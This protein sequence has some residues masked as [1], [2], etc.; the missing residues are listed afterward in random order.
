MSRRPEL[1]SCVTATVVI[2]RI[3]VSLGLP[4]CLTLTLDD[5]RTHEPPA[6]VEPLRPNPV[7][8]DTW[9]VCRLLG[10]ATADEGIYGTDLGYTAPLPGTDRLAV[11]FG[12]TW[13]EVGDACQYPVE[14][15]DDLQATLPAQRP[16]ELGA[17]APSE[18]ARSSVCGTLEPT[19]DDP[20][21]PR[22]WRRIR[23][24][25]S[26]ADR[27][28]GV[29]MDTTALRTPVAA[30]SDGAS[31]YTLFSRADVAP[32]SA[33]ADCPQGMGCSAE[34]EPL[35]RCSQPLAL[36][37]DPVPQL[38]R[39]EDDCLLDLACDF[40]GGGVCQSDTPFVLEASMTGRAAI[41]PSWYRDDPRRGVAHTMYVAIASVAERPEDYVVAHRFVTRRFVDVSAR[42][43]AHFDPDDAS[44][45]DYAY[46]EHTLLLWGRPDFVT[47]DGVQS[48]P[49]LLYVPLDELREEPSVFRPR[50][51]AGYGQ[52]GKPRWSELESES[53]PIY[54]TDVDAVDERK[55]ETR[56]DW[57][58]PEFDYVN[59]MSVAYLAPLE[60][61]IMVYGGDVP[62]FL[63]SDAEGTVALSTHVQPMPGAIHQRVA[64]HP[65]GRA[66]LD[67]PDAD[68]WSS[69]K[70]LLTRERA[71]PY[72][73]CGPDEDKLPKC[74]TESDANSPLDL[75]ET[76]AG[77]VV[78]DPS[79]ALDVTA[80]CL[81]GSAARA[82]QE[83]A[84]GS[85]VGRLYGANVIEEWTQDV[86]DQVDGLE[87]DQ[88]A[89]EIYW[90]VS[91]WNPYQV[92]L[93][94]SRLTAAR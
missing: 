25:A 92:V 27:E 51:F 62:A 2:L 43:I 30:W 39:D 37:E 21:E 32:C 79:E 57:S 58:E 64:R 89:V 18:A 19:L 48:L 85:P 72:L 52:D 12:D 63:V 15:S 44:Q 26:E 81:E 49:F 17:G 46:G 9:D 83:G 4:A 23:L 67:A 6:A 75:A 28:A 87:Q 36:S 14:V 66:T 86:S 22:S 41:S 68:A 78:D 84:S 3:T 42:T 11:L 88:A 13:S 53:Q 76:I 7:E 73:A 77:A 10:P 60:R 59:Q 38:C 93:M 35:G 47:K 40:D 8:S 29:R 91:T 70:A 34:T 54:G 69:P 74:T 24:F 45:N 31:V 94:K 65:W 5:P 71:A 61:F 80:T 56:I 50:F 33:A 1:R 20:D 82:A 55:G 90:N 16:E